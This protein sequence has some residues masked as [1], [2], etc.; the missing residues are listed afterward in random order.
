MQ[1]ILNLLNSSSIVTNYEIFDFKQ[2]KNFYFVKARAE[3]IDNSYLH[4]K[5][6]NSTG[7]Y[8]YSFHWQDYNN[9]LIVRWDNS[10]HHEYIKAFPHHKHIGGKITESNEFT[11]GD[12]LKYIERELG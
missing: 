7:E 1:K 3:I 5:I 4:I 10:P 11:L 9:D 12:I 6:F 2:G 8:F